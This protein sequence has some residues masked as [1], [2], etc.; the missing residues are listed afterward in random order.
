M[1]HK[2]ISELAEGSQAPW[3]GTCPGKED[4]EQGV[5]PT[6]EPYLWE[7]QHHHYVPESL[8]PWERCRGDENTQA[9]P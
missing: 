3:D 5:S 7:E 8:V 9:P 2:S 1:R 6:W 4:W